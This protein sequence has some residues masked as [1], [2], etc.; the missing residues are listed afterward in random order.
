MQE[1][2]N[3]MFARQKAK[4]L[5]RFLLVVLLFSSFVILV[6][7]YIGLI[8]YEKKLDT[9]SEKIIELSE[10]RASVVKKDSIHFEQYTNNAR[11]EY[12]VQSSN[13][14]HDTI[15]IADLAL[16]RNPIRLAR[17]EMYI[18]KSDSF[19]IHAADKRYS[20]SS[21]SKNYSVGMLKTEDSRYF[22][23]VPVPFKVVDSRIVLEG[24]LRDPD[25][26]VFLHMRNDSLIPV[27][28]KTMK[29][30]YRDISYIYTKENIQITDPYGNIA[31]L[32]RRVHGNNLSAVQIAGYWWTG[33]DKL[34]SIIGVKGSEL[35]EKGNLSRDFATIYKKMNIESPFRYENGKIVGERRATTNPPR[36]I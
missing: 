21:S 25:G 36:A 27:Q 28:T 4:V 10:I 29:L 3:V 23:L 35:I 15:F 20:Y 8:A 7:F 33:A 11:S 13:L 24:T 5:L 2:I 19:Y 18:P 32:I 30:G 12:K 9:L 26:N 14:I 16:E 31:L 6:S 34:V 1:G 22:A 17:S